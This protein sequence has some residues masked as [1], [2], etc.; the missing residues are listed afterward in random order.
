MYLHRTIHQLATVQVSPKKSGGS[1]TAVSKTYGLPVRLKI[2]KL[3]V[4]TAILYMGLTSTGDMEVPADLKNVGWYKYGPHPGDSGSA[5]IAG[6]L[7]GY[8]DKGV[9]IA[10][11]TLVPGDIVTVVDDAGISRNFAVRESHSYDQ[12][13]RPSKIFNTNDKLAHLN[14]ITC[15]GIWH[16]SEK[17]YSQR[18]VVFT[19]R[20]K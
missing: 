6:H 3:G 8:K 10:L 7:E 12:H 20:I 2:P 1:P 15:T 5:V 11:D 14:L 19:D 16:E 13:D 18:L 17:R 4:D 9:F